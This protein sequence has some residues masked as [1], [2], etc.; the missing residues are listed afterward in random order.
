M[1]LPDSPDSPFYQE[2]IEH[3]RNA[4]V[5]VA[6]WDF[7]HW[8]TV[9]F[10]FWSRYCLSSGQV[11]CRD[12]Y[13]RHHMRPWLDHPWLFERCRDLQAN[14]DNR[15]FR[16]ARHHFKSTL[17]T[18]NLTLWE[19]IQN[20]P[21]SANLRTL[22]LTYKMDVAGEAF[23]GGIKR[24]CEQN[25][26]L[27][28]HWPEV[29]FADPANE[30]PLWTKHALLFRRTEKDGAKEPSIKV[31][32]LDNQPTSYHCDL[33]IGDDL[34]TRESVSSEDQIKKCF[35][36][37]QTS[38]FLGEPGVTRRRYAGT[39]WA[40]DDAWSRAE[41][42]GF[43]TTDHHSCYHPD[44]T[45]VLF[46][47]KALEDWERTSGRYNFSVQMLGVP[48]HSSERI[49]LM[50]W[51]QDYENDPEY[52]AKNKTVYLFADLALA[53]EESDYSVIAAIGLGPDRKK[54]LLDLRR[55]RWSPW[56]FDEQLLEMGQKWKPVTAYIEQ[57]A[58]MTD[59]ERVREKMRERRWR[60]LRV[61]PL[62]RETKGKEDDSLSVTT[63]GYKSLMIMRLQDDMSR[64]AWYFPR[65]TGY[66]AKGENRDAM[67][68]FIE[69][70]YR[71]WTPGAKIAHDDML[72]TLAM[73]LNKNLNLVW[74]QDMAAERRKEMEFRRPRAKPRD[75]RKSYAGWVV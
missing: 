55:D 17:V 28:F 60:G 15:L 11:L 68:V 7:R 12:P 32:G 24:E 53:G 14:P 25:K 13:N 9:D 41:R 42:A 2:L 10:W 71:Q 56:E 33:I 59:V 4:P 61:E 38:T 21:Q 6:A 29:F 52:E 27:H 31:A 1:N 58:M 57:F 22:I 54:Y 49:F 16:W 19:Y 67:S 35:A 62:P 51:L 3:I 39:F 37:M 23:L 66:R 26:L 75:Y 74:P 18:T 65:A 30:S 73:V 36:N 63:K 70:E 64:L 8:C 34:V 40:I 43:F 20:L 46:S 69:E 48:V 50:D 44:G 72:N 45:P 5:E 47:Q